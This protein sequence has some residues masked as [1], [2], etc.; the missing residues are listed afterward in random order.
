MQDRLHFGERLDS[1]VASEWLS[2]QSLLARGRV[3]WTAVRRF[4]SSDVVSIFLATRLAFLL[5]TYFGRALVRDP[6]LVGQQNLDLGS[7][8]SLIDAWFYRDSQWYLTIVNDGYHYFG[9]GHRSAVAFFPVYPMLVKALH[10]LVHLDPGICAMIVANLSFLG[11]LIYLHRLCRREF[12]E[13]TARRAVFYMAIFPTS[14]FSFAPYSESLFLMLSIGTLYYLRGGR[15][16]VAGIFGGLAA[17]TRIIG[18]VLAL[19]FVWEYLRAR[20][21]R[22]RAIRLDA[23]AG[24]L[25]PG[26]LG[27]YML[28]LI[29]LTGDPLAFVKSEAGWNRAATPPWQVLTDSLRDVPR[30]GELGQYLQAHALIE[31]ALVLGC[32]V[33]LLAGIRRIPFAWIL[34]GVTS[35][36]ILLSAPVTTSPIPITSMSRYLFVLSPVFIILATLGRWPIFDRLYVLL[37]VG[38]LALFST[39]FINHM[40]GA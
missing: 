35:L 29:G 16:W 1:F 26:G 31:N 38:G 32:L 5:L 2:K 27:A 36:L 18:V 11:A 39:L 22:F 34:F 33:V 12:G 20:E 25:I 28:Y 21:F 14:F 23:L 3:V 15:W 17:A 13:S 7:K 9:A 30:A 8:G 37:S 40:W 4:M 6:A 19:A 10:A 24:A